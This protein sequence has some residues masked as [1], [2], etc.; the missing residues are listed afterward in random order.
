MKALSIRTPALG[1]STS[2]RA[3]DMITNWWSRGEEGC[4]TEGTRQL[5]IGF[6]MNLCPATDQGQRGRPKPGYLPGM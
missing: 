4:P 1:K 5:V 2:P 6:Y 3:A